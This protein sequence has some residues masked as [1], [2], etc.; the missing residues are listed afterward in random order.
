MKSPTSGKHVRPAIN[1]KSGASADCAA[2]LQIPATLAEPGG[3]YLMAWLRHRALI[4]Y[5]CFLLP[6][7]FANTGV[8]CWLLDRYVED[9]QYPLPSIAIATASNLCAAILI[10]SE[11]IINLLF[12]VF[13]SVPTWAPLRLRRVCTNVFHLGGIHVSCAIAAV[14]WFLIFTIGASLEMGKNADESTIAVAP[15]VLS[16]FILALLLAVS[17]SSYSGL[18]KRHH[19]RW[20]A[21][22]R[23]GGWML[24]ILY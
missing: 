5:R 23:Y 22:H 18:R 17:S 10:R 19:D 13:L 14:F 8:A 12:Y 2:P 21:L 9:G 16:Y 3:S 20:E 11:P 7:L 15:T 4:A 1:V 6:I 24:L